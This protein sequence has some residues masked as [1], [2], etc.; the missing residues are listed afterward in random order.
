MEKE[1]KS[2]EKSITEEDF[3]RAVNELIVKINECEPTYEEVTKDLDENAKE[4]I[5]S[6]FVLQNIATNLKV[7][8]T[9][10]KLK[11]ILFEKENEEETNND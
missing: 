1:R 2:D 6:I 7:I 9:I 5:G 4:Q 11:S 3:D 10:K 8:M